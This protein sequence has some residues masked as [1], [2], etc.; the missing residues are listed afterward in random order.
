[1]GAWSGAITTF[2]KVTVN[3]R[4]GRWEPNPKR[5]QGLVQKRDIFN[6]R[7]AIFVSFAQKYD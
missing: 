5:E 3:V 1:M 2:N 7:I 6:L 4:R